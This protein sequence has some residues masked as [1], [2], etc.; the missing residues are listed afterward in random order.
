MR[1]ATFSF[2]FSSAVEMR[3]VRSNGR[4]PVVH[5]LEDVDGLGRGV[6]GLEHAAAE[7]HARGLDLLREADL[8]LA[9]EQRDR[10]HL[11][12]VHTNRIIDPLGAILGNGF[13]DRRTS[14]S[15]SSS[16]LR[17]PGRLDRAL[18]S[19]TSRRRSSEHSGIDSDARRSRTRR[20]FRGSSRLN[21]KS[22]LQRRVERL[23]AAPAHERSSSLSISMSRRSIEQDEQV[24]R[25]SGRGRPSRS[26]SVVIQLF[27][28][29]PSSFPTQIPEAD[30]DRRVT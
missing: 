30:R 8:L 19:M 6:V 10:A 29:D 25:A 16:S 13:L 2:A 27:I 7:D 12:E 23:V 11:R 21:F 24:R 18:R 22:G 15:A 9:R 4:L 17:P 26:G 3:I 5:L 28:A 14:A 20:S 1:L